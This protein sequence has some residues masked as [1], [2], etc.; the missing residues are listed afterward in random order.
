MTIQTLL[1][2]FF[3]LLISVVLATYQYA[4]KTKL[5]I[6]AKWVYGSLR[7]ITFFSILILLINPKFKTHNYFL[8][9]PNLPILI[10][11]SE[12]INHFN[13]G[14]MVTEFV[15]SIKVNKALNDKFDI[16]YYTFGNE[17][18]LLDSLTFSEKNTNIYNALN[19]TNSVYDHEVAP[20]L[21]ITDG[22]QTLGSDYKYIASQYRNAIYPIIVGDSIRYSDLKITS[23]LTNRYSFLNN[24]FPAELTVAYEG[25]LPVKTNLEITRGRTVVYRKNITFSEDNST[26]IIAFTLPSEE[27][28][29]QKYSVQIAPL[30]NERNIQN[31]RKEFAIEVIDESTDIFLVSDIKH[32]DMGV[33]KK[34]IE[35]N[36]QRIVTVYKPKEALRNIEEAQLI[37]LFQP[38]SS[39]SELLQE[40]KKLNKNTF[41]FTGLQTDWNFLNKNQSNF[42]KEVTNQ[43]ELVGG[44]L[45][46]NFDYFFLEDLGF[47][48]FR[49]LKTLFGDLTILN[50]NEVILDQYIN[51]YRSESPLLAIIESNLQREAIWDAEGLWKWR[52]QS[53]LETKNHE[54]FDNFMGALIQYLA[55][56]KN[57]SRFEINFKNIYYNNNSIKISAQYFD[58][59]FVFN[60]NTT[61][62]IVA[63]NL[64][65]REQFTSP[66]IL[67]RNYYEVDLSTLNAGDYSFSVTAE[68]DVK[69][70]RTGSFTVFDYNVEQQFLNPDVTK[71][72]KL[73]T[74]T[75]GNIS[76]LSEAAQILE[77]LVD[78]ESFK[79]IQKKSEKIKPLIEFEYILMLIII[80]L[81]LE[82]FIRKY[83][84]LT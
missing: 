81:S 29:L 56:N 8:V 72:S 59:N 20:T 24:Q 40:I 51:G 27:V 47:S 2:I 17:F 16:H 18:K 3:A 5:T 44:E 21:L 25:L 7:F 36:E 68:E 10:D 83:N 6:Q 49:P 9:K 58:K 79:P 32:P 60:P 28:G 35:T 15:T 67:K 38:N 77:N 73:A 78:D 65:T 70:T 22:N 11:N 62:T 61:I 80:S 74:N 63:T 55:T 69:L 76:F 26:K 75:S 12:S 53:F 52:A 64:D 43:T 31:N 30:N 46:P 39:F 82:W 66:L 13:Y 42:S 45:N 41:T 54:S 50:K 4:Y 33:L 48:N 23:V 37:I 14:K 19:L 34:S 57:R 1:F 84:G 71:L